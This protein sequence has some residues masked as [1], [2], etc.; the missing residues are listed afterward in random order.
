MGRSPR[1]ERSRQHIAEVAA[2]ILVEEGAAN[3][4]TAKLKAAERLGIQDSRALPSN[5]EI[6]LAVHAYQRLFHPTEHSDALR[7]KR[8]EAIQAMHFFATFSPRLIG[9]VLS[10]V[11]QEHAAIELHLFC[12]TPELVELFLLEHR[13]SFQRSNKRYVINSNAAVMLPALSFI[14]IN[15]PIDATIFPLQGLREAPR[16]A[17]NGELIKRANAKT[18]AALI[19]ESAQTEARGHT[20]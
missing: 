3:L 8:E 9:S 18:V 15:T 6:E 16:S 7:A 5:Q 14:A 13:I 12:D 4:H 1:N 17:A 20:S 11:A 2:R 19:D 10:G